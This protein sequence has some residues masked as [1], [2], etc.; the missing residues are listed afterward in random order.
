VQIEPGQFGFWLVDIVKIAQGGPLMALDKN[1]SIAKTVPHDLNR[2]PLP[3]FQA[4]RRRNLRRDLLC[5]SNEG[6]VASRYLQTPFVVI[7][8]RSFL[9]SERDDADHEE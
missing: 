1:Q 2:V 8:K 4:M 7:I 5:I 6:R 3:S 9:F